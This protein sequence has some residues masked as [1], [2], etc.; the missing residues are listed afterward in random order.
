MNA[1][2]ISLFLTL[3]VLSASAQYAIRWSTVDGGGVASTNGGYTLRGTLGQPEA[4]GPMTNGP[5]TLRGGFWV[6]PTVVQSE[7]APTLMIA[8]A[9]VGQAQISWVASTNWVL[10]ESI[11][12]N[13]AAWA[14]SPS[15]TSNP[16][17]V[18]ATF[19][20]KF[21]RLFKP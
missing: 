20:T 16:V 7:G 8:P 2:Q 13:P 14:N 21:Y 5:Y 15:G 1:K 6:L 9:G 17:I 4:G 3:G 19:P 10:Q 18:P 12:L 11:N